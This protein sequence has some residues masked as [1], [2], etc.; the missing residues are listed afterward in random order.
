MKD[1][2]SGELDKHEGQFDKEREK[3][4]EIMEKKRE[5]S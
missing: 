2:L 1:F 4:I 3:Y 5:D